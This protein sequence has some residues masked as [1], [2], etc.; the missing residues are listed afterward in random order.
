MKFKY[1]LAENLRELDNL[2]TKWL[3]S[4]LSGFNHLE[5]NF[6]LLKLSKFKTKIPNR[7]ELTIEKELKQN[8]NL[9]FK[10]Q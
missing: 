10:Q 4:L 3:L 6:F 5:F 7:R 9:K 2:I 8:R 1:F